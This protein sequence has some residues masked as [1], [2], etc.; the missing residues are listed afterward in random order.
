[1]PAPCCLGRFVH[2]LGR[3]GVHNGGDVVPAIITRVW[4]QTTIAGHDVWVV[5]LLMLHDGP[6]V[7]WRPSVYVFADEATARRV[8]GWNAWWPPETCGN[9][10]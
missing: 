6:Q 10:L 8:P 1:M 5:N 7:V 9:H 4:D 2:A 3:L